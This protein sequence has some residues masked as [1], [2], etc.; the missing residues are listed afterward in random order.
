MDVLRSIPVVW[1]IVA[2][3]AGFAGLAAPAVL[4]VQEEVAAS[5]VIAVLAVCAI[6]SGIGIVAAV[7]RLET[8]TRILLLWVAA[9][10]AG[11]AGV[12]TIMSGP[13]I[14]ML[15]VMVAYL[16]SAWGLNESGDGS[17]LS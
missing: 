6:P 8:R 3:V 7:T 17:R 4:S 2:V 5:S 1:R 15:G 10:T 12:I 11:F 9:L 16:V 14:I 13:G